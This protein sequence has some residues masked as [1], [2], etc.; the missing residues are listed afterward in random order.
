M[1]DQY[2]TSVAQARESM[3][4]ARGHVCAVCDEIAEETRLVIVATGDRLID[5]IRSL[6]KV[7]SEYA[8]DKPIQHGHYDAARV[9]GVEFR[10]VLLNLDG[11]CIVENASL[12]EDVA[13]DVARKAPS[14]KRSRARCS[15]SPSRAF[16]R[17][18]NSS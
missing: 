3:W 5:R 14:A 11:I 18:T 13:W 7:R 16:R 17:W 6:C 1:A 8:D 2:A 10:D 12:A 9:L 4:R 15:T